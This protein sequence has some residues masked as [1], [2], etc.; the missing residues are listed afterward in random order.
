MLPPVQLE[1]VE[2]R[3]IAV[4][5]RRAPQSELTRAVPEACGA[6]WIHFRKVGFK[7]TGR[8]VAVYY[9]NAITFEAGAEVTPP[10]EGGD[11]VYL[12]ATPAGLAAHAVHRGPYRGLHEA[13]M[14]IRR[15]C[16]TNGQPSNGINWEVYGHWTEDES[17]L[18]TDVYY[19]LRPAVR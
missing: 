3:P 19:L 11:G 7:R 9:D 17:S 18:V 2:P 14:A 12:S 15:W 6:A 1:Q 8:N 16:E 4:V 5:K 10:F 13:H